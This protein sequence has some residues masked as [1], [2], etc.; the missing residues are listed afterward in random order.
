[1]RNG[2]RGHLARTWGHANEVW[3]REV[4]DLR[5]GVEDLVEERRGERICERRE[6]RKRGRRG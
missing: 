5:V 4:D 2:C 6:T 1:M 3:E